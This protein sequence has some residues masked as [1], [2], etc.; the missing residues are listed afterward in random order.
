M[1]RKLSVFGSGE[2]LAKTGEWTISDVA[3]FYE[4]SLR[5]LRFYEDKGLLSPRR[6]G[7]ARFYNGADRV[8]LELILKGKR[9]GFTLSEIYVLIASRTKQNAAGTTDDGADL[10]VSLGHKQIMTQIQHL[11]KQRKDLDEAILELRQASARM[12]A[13]AS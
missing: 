9:L 2:G 8:R 12:E 11:E 13:V 1:L 5:T 7:T 10:T 3:R 4:V 6:Q